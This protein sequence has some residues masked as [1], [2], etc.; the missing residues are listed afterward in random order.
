MLK[1]KARAAGKY[2]AA[3]T[4]QGISM[5]GEPKLGSMVKTGADGGGGSTM[6]SGSVISNKVRAAAGEYYAAITAH[7]G[8]GPETG[9]KAKGGGP[10]FQG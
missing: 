2:A 5:F 3:V 6:R 9:S 7:R 8:N 1:G 10:K 4:R